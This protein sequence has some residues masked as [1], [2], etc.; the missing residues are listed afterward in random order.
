LYAKRLSPNP[1]FR[2]LPAP[3]ASSELYGDPQHIRIRRAPTT[4]DAAHAA[5]STA[6]TYSD[7]TWRL[8]LAAKINSRAREHEGRRKKAPA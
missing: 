7:I 5:L 2:T 6:L 1:W 3:R 4:G 8:E